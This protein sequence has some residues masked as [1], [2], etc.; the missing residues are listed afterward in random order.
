[1]TL[2]S[3]QLLTIPFR[4]ENEL[5]ALSVLLN[6]YKDLPMSLA[7]ACLVRMTEQTT[8]SAVFTLDSDFRVYRNSTFQICGASPR[9]VNLRPALLLR[10]YPATQ[11]LSF[12]HK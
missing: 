8:D 10:E 12:S 2:L 7:D 1:M 6:K 9:Q 11:W 4:L 3:R 5:N